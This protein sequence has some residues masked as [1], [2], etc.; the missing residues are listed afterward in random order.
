MLENYYCMCYFIVLMSSLL[1]YNVENSTN[2]E[3]PLN[4]SVCPN[5]VYMYICRLL[6]QPS[7]N[8]PDSR[9]WPGLNSL[10]C[11]PWNTL[12]SGL[13]TIVVKSLKKFDA[14]TRYLHN[15]IIIILHSS[16]L[17]CWVLQGPSLHHLVPG[18]S[19]QFF[20]LHTFLQC[21]SETTS[22]PVFSLFSTVDGER[23]MMKG[24]RLTSKEMLTALQ[25][26]CVAKD[27]QAK[28]TAKKQSPPSVFLMCLCIFVNVYNKIL[29]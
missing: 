27:P 25:S 21:L 1:F 26:R 28:I 7:I 5:C 22:L 29:Y 6:C 11:T 8:S 19:F 3:K 2:K 14:M 20:V 15:E 13:V 23:L 10:L 12:V 4:E 17:A 9:C 24:A 18:N 16:N